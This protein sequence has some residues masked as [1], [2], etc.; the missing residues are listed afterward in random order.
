MLGIIRVICG[1]L[2]GTLLY[3]IYR[4]SA[5]ALTLISNLAVFWAI[6][7]CALAFFLTDGFLCHAII[8][9]LCFPA[10]LLS[11]SQKNNYLSQFFSTKSMVWL[12]TISYGLYMSHGIV[13]KLLKVIV[14]PDKFS[15]SSLAVRSGVLALNV[16]ALLAAAIFLYYFIETPCRKWLRDIRLRNNIG[17]SRRCPPGGEVNSSS[18]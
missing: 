3:G 17:F 11:L 4:Q 9:T 15:A 8:L 1:F 7:T 16:T 2:A 12:G 18:G 14:N 13:E 10:L 6:I 5:L